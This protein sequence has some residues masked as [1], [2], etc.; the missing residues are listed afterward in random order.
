MKKKTLKKLPITLC[1]ITH[2]SG[3]RIK[4]MI[5]KHKDVVSEVMIVVQ[6]SSDDTLARAREVA[7]VVIE[8]RCKG[9]SDPDRN[10]LFNLVSNEWVLY[11]DDD[12]YVSPILKGKLEDLIKQNIDIYWFKRTNLVD[13]VDIFDILKNDMQPRLFKRGSVKF[14]NRIHTY[15]EKAPDAFAGFVEYDI[16]HDRTL[17]QVKKGNRV[18]NSVANREQVAMQEKFISQ[19]EAL[20]EE[21]S[22]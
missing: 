19:V 12:E 16:I 13:G 10:W 1:V 8:K 11:L 6:K 17:D 7:D 20:L 3:N 9:T 21:K 4:E 15:P 2:N 5:L 18:R 22:A 14:P